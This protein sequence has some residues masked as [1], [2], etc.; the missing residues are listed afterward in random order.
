MILVVDFGSQTAHLIQRRVKEIG[1]ESKFVTPDKAIAEIKKNKKIKGIIL[2]GGP[3]SVYAKNSPTI[4]PQI[5]SFGIPVLGICY[6]F[7]TMAKLLGGRVIAGRKEYGPA[8]LKLK[9]ITAKAG[10]RLETTSGKNLKLKIIKD[11]P[12]SFVV[13]MSHGDEIIKLPKGFEVIG[14]TNHVSFAFSFDNKR[15]LYGLLFHPEVEHTQNGQKILENFLKI[16]SVGLTKQETNPPKIVK[17]IR[18]KV[19]KYS[20]I[21]AVSG[22]VDSTVASVLVATAIGKNF[23]PV[24]VDNGLMRE[25]TNTHLSKIFK[26][27]GIKLNVLKVE[28]EMLKRLKKIID[29]EQKRKIIGNFYIEL[30]E[31]EMEKLIK[32]GKKIK[33]LLQGTIYS[34][35]IESQGTKH[36]D[37]IKSHH[38]VGGLPKKMR[39]Q[40]LEPLRELYKDEV[41]KLGQKLGLPE[42]FVNMQPFPGPG[43]AINIMGV[44]TQKRLEQ[45]RKADQI[46]VEEIKKARLYDKVFECFAVMTGA[47]STAVKG[48]GRSYA[49]VVAIRS[50]DTENLMTADWTKI[51]FDVLQRIASRIVNEVPDISRVVYDVTTKPPATVRWE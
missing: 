6:G 19:G 9:V 14:S 46:V 49:E 38:N 15:K 27:I 44:V 29:S 51:P 31:K 21:G 16:C 50:I 39:L 30:F 1:A 20:V 10:S 33:F 40:L 3:S 22:G 45:V 41:R 12:K 37:K 28:K 4:D 25:G 2:S 7:Q 26:H 36:S 8:T 24:Y 13:W 23:Y 34:D 43:H 47:Y 42:E 35:V 5:F 18:E 32:K 17:N 48:D 11:L